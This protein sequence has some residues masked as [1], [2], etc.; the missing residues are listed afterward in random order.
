MDVLDLQLRIPGY[1]ALDQPTRT[2][3]RN[4]EVFQTLPMNRAVQVWRGQIP[5][6]VCLSAQVLDAAVFF[7]EA[8]EIS[9]HGRRLRDCVGSMCAIVSALGKEFQV[10]IEMGMTEPS[11]TFGNTLFRQLDRKEIMRRGVAVAFWA[12]T[13][14]AGGLL[15]ALVQRLLQGG[16]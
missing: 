14:I 6:E 9:I 15:G 2:A 5:T 7:T 11:D 13:L 1:P 10:P 3:L 8:W 4:L 12:L 16:S